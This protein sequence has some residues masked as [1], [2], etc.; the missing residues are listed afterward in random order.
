MAPKNVIV[1]GGCGYIGSHTLISL[2]EAGYSPIVIDN[3]ANSSKETL[4]KVQSITKKKFDFF[5]IN[6][7]DKKKLEKVFMN[8]KIHAVIHFAALKVVGD[9]WSN[10]IDYFENNVY[11]SLNL[12]SLCEK[13][14]VERFI[15]SSSANVYG[16]DSKTPI[17]ESSA[18]SPSNPYGVSKLMVE[19]ILNNLFQ[20]QS[21]YKKNNWKIVILRYFN[22]IGAHQ[23]G[24]IGEKTP[25][26]PTN[27]MPYLLKVASK[28]LEKFTIYGDDYNTPDGTGIR[29][30]IHVMDLSEGHVSALKKVEELD[31]GESY[32]S[33]INL[34]TGRGISV[35][36]LLNN[37]SKYTNIEIPYVVEERRPG[38]IPISF[39][40]TS[41][42]KKELSWSAERS[43]KDMIID[44]WNWQK[45]I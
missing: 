29:D 22:P 20:A 26:I 42:A 45:K 39:A 38:D 10:T 13:Y 21:V 31:D 5:E 12:L 23:S 1:T 30:Y 43:L 33:V 27:I 37:F 32:H 41:F 28:K 24:L 34:G 11:G 14:H 7:I 9:S 35:K 17:K 2:I 19:N 15:F 18:L 3:L 8:K 36:E 6:I 4:D 25:E 40:D 44:S 16:L